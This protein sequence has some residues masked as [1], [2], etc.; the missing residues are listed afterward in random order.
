[1]N[2]SAR[3]RSSSASSLERKQNPI[4]ALSA[5]SWLKAIQSYRKLENQKRTLSLS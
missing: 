4:P 1:M 2:E 5:N 3:L